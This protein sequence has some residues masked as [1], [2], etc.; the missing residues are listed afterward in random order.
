MLDLDTGPVQLIAGVRVHLDHPQFTIGLV[1]ECDLGCLAVADGHLL[2]V[3]LREQVIPAGDFLRYGIEAA[4]GQGDQDFT[5]GVG[6]ERADGL[7]VWAG[8]GEDGALQGVLR[9]RLQ[10]DNFQAGVG[11]IILRAVRVIADS[12]HVQLHIVVQVAD[13]ILQI[14][15]LVFLLADGVHSCVLGHGRGKGELDAPG[16]ARHA[17]QGIEDFELAGVAVTGAAGGNSGDLLVIHVHDLGPSGYAGR[18]GKGHGHVIVIYPRLAPNGKDLLLALLAVDGHGIGGRLVRRDSHARVQ[19][20]IVGGAPLVDVLGGGQDAV[21]DVQLAP[22]QARGYFEVI[23]GPVGE[24]IA[25]EGH[26]GGIVGLILV[27][28]AQ[29]PQAAV[30]IAVGNDTHHL[31]IAGFFLG[32][33]FDALTGAHSLGHAVLIWIHAVR[34]RLLGSPVVGLV[35]KIGIN[36]LADRAV[37]GEIPQLVVAVIDV[38][39]A[40]R[41]L[42]AVGGKG[43]GGQQAQGDDKSQEQG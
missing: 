37:D 8:H 35:K 33:I 13:I 40:Q 27:V 23:D 28:Q 2:G 24:Q 9:S 26:L 19:H 15:V 20:V 29:F 42:H 30:G 22:G 39:L 25:P 34:R 21:A 5:L 11:G 18:V 17:L 6:G 10:L 12:G 31:G 7:P 41:G 3:L 36:L 32:Q 1:P 38:D 16:L 14:A 4:E 43:P